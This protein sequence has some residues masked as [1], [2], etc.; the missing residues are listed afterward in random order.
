MVH[1]Q[2][3]NCLQSFKLLS[4]VQ[5]GIRKNLSTSN[6]INSMLQYVYDELVRNQIVLSLFLDFRKAFDCVNHKILPKKMKKLGARG[7]ALKWFESYLT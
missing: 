5:F 6:A 7:I 2:V 3:Y 1:H 4:S